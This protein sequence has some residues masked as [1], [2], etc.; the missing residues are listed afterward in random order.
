MTRA[1]PE[2][3]IMHGN[4]GRIISFI[5]LS[6]SSSQTLASKTQRSGRHFVN[7]ARHTAKLL[8]IYHRKDSEN[9]ICDRSKLVHGFILKLDRN[10]VHV[11]LV[12][13]LVVIKDYES[14]FD[15][16]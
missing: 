7:K 13:K 10:T 11:S 2:S 14:A 1:Q 6:K 4:R 5:I 9:G 12:L 16:V 3:T 8:T 15:A